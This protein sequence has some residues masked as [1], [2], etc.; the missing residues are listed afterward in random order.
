MPR[1]AGVGRSSPP[2]ARRRFAGQ[3]RQLLCLLEIDSSTFGDATAVILVAVPPVP[4]HAQGDLLGAVLHVGDHVRD[5]VVTLPWLE[6]A[7]TLAGLAVVVSGLG[8]L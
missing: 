8:G 2:L 7:V 3:R 1:S 4:H 6:G 5:Q